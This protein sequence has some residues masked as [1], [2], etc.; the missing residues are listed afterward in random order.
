MS[1]CL[2][3]LSAH[4]SFHFFSYPSLR[5]LLFLCEAICLYVY[6]YIL[7][8]PTYHSTH[9]LFYPRYIDN[10]F[11][12]KFI[13]V[14]YPITCLCLSL[15]YLLIYLIYVHSYLS[16]HAPVYLCFCDLSS[17]LF[18]C[19]ISILSASRSTRFIFINPLV[20]LS[21][22]SDGVRK[23]CICHGV[24]TVV[25][26]KFQLADQKYRCCNES[27]GWKYKEKGA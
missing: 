19:V 24:N 7:F 5:F 25:P 4:L 26:L 22:L 12:A 27:A 3:D 16:I 8:F 17:D 10:L 15:S 18:T 6:I 13:N 20:W 21:K 14:P 2:F 1:N 23:Y 9:Q 11:V